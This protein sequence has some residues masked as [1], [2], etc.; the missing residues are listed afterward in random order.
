MK[1]F[2]SLFLISTLLIPSSVFAFDPESVISDTDFNDEYA[3]SLNQIQLFLMKGFLGGYSTE[4]HAGVR[5]SAAEIIYNAAIAGSVSPKVLL[6]TLQKEQS[7]VLSVN[8]TQKQLDWA[9]GYAVCDSCSMD[10]PVLVRWQGF[11]KQINSAA[12]QFSET[13]GYM[14]DIA[15]TGTTQGKYGPGVP[16]EID[17]ETI[18]PANAATAALYAYTPH[19]HGQE[20]FHDLWTQWFSTFHPSGTLLKAD[21]APDVYLIEFGQKRLIANWSAFVSRFDAS[22]IISVSQSQ[23]DGFLD[24]AP[25]SFPNYS[26]FEDESGVKYLLVDDAVRPFVSNE[27]FYSLGFK[28]DELVLISASDLAL[29]DLG[30]LINAAES[31]PGGV[32][33]QLE[34]SGALF[35]VQEGKRH[36][37]ASEEIANARFPRHTITSAGPGVIEQ[38]LD[39]PP[40][41]L[42]DGILIKSSDDTTVYVLSEGKRR[43]IPTE[44]IFHAYGWSFNDVLTLSDA[45]VNFHP[46]GTVIDTPSFLE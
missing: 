31:N 4:D 38:F 33:Y 7:L 34:T 36:Y 12:L 30:T 9:M 14:Y 40:I 29:F 18:T 6:A 3:M 37:I 21:G 41:L 15:R 2:I 16:V 43:S 45:S 28:D 24:G 1:T 23:V 25:I 22:R 17:D 42:P 13:E 19:F 46:L 35:F 39:G 20:L 11:G 27:V 32:V 44:E 26:I 5:R 8:P 10:D